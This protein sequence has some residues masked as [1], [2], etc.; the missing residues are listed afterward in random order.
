MILNSYGRPTASVLPTLRVDND[1][2]GILPRPE[3]L[4]TPNFRTEPTSFQPP[5]M[6]EPREHQVFTYIVPPQEMIPNVTPGDNLTPILLPIP[7]RGTTFR[8]HQ[9]LSTM[10]ATVQGSGFS[11]QYFTQHKLVA[12]P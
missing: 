7:M 1:Q 3:Q 5:Q 2:R 10:Q 9:P 11:S 12:H 8:A 6:N 4:Y